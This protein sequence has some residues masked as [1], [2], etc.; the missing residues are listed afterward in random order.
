MQHKLT[1]LLHMSSGSIFPPTPDSRTSV[2]IHSVHIMGLA[3]MYV[4][5]HVLQ[6]VPNSYP[7]SYLRLPWLVWHIY[8]CEE[9]GDLLGPT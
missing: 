9:I 7:P 8:N 1:S 5:Q 6:L 4:V 2:G 3:R